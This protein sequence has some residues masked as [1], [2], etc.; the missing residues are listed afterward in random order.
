M[1]RRIKP[2]KY[3][4]NWSF[5]INCD[6]LLHLMDRLKYTNKID[7]NIKFTYNN[8]KSSA[9]TIKLPCNNKKI[10]IIIVSS[11]KIAIYYMEENEKDFAFEFINNL[12]TEHRDEIEKKDILQ[13][14]EN[15][16]ILKQFID[17]DALKKIS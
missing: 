3:N 13:L 4:L 9:F 5:K 8:I 15:D 17:I 6:R 14:I 1:D 2:N 16:E 11:G 7:E 10:N 12:L